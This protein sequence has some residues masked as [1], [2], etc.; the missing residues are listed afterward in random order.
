MIKFTKIMLFLLSFSCLLQSCLKDTNKQTY[1]IYVP[2]YKSPAEVRANIKTTSP[3]PIVHPGKIFVRGNYIFLNEVDKGVHIIDNTNPNSPI[4]KF[5]IPI[6]G[7][8]DVAV[9]G[10]TLYVDLYRDLVAIDIA[11]PA[12]VKVEKII[13]KVFP[14][15]MYTNGFIPDSTMVVVDWIKKDTT[16][17]FFPYTRGIANAF[18]IQNI[19]GVNTTTIQPA[20]VGGS[21]ARFTLMGNYLYTVTDREL[22]VFNIAQPNNPLYS[23]MVPIGW[24]IETIFPFKSNLF[25]GSQTGMFIYNTVDPAHPALVSQFSH[26]TSC[27][28]VIADDDYAYV[29]LRTGTACVGT[30]NQLD[31]LNIQNL[32]S[33]TLVHSYPLTNPH[34]LSKTGNSL[35]IC[36]GSGGLKVFDATDKNNLQLLQ[37][38][39]GINAY[40]IILLNNIAIVVATDGLYQ[41]DISQPDNITLKSNIRY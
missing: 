37:T 18:E 9:K 8:L 19:G 26:L 27:D 12:S 5:F 30:I 15:R 3:Q 33:P 10:N 21:M 11:N 36:D 6:P 16:T 31:I 14:T 20:G 13:D 29:T 22:N 34:G 39:S 32:Q 4:N 28:P 23:N 24:R 41:Y 38:V 25:I 40:D 7:N 17:Q 2:V 1:T 35:F